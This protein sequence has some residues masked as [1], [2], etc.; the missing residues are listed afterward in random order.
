MSDVHEQMEVAEHA[1][2][3]AHD[4]KHIALLIAILALCLALSEMLAK[5]ANTEALTLNIK[6]SDTWNFYQAKSIRRTVLL[7]A[8]DEMKVESVSITGDAKSAMDKQ[9]AAWQ[10]TAARYQS[11]PKPDGGEGTKEL[12]ERAKEAE[13]ERDTALARYHNYEFASAA[14]QIGIVLC[15]AAIITA[16]LSLAWTAGGVAI[17]GLV[18]VAFGLFAPHLLHLG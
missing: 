10:E 4:S 14:F 8:A 9:I 15:S 18:F 16:M 7:A 5:S 1:K 3:A 13:H 6:V 17:A 11:E 2:H 12:F